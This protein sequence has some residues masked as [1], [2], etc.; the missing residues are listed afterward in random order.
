MTG[1]LD[2]P[3]ELRIHIF[4]YVP[5]LCYGR[6]E[7]VGP[8]VRLTP[9]ICRA[10]HTLRRDALLLYAKTSFFIIQSDDS[11]DRVHSSNETRVSIWLNTLGDRALSYVE[12]LQLSR[13]WKL[14]QPSRWQGHVG[15]YVRLQLL[16]KKWQ[17]T[18]GTYPVAHDIRG[19]R[20]ESVDL[21][22]YLISQRLQSS[23]KVGSEMGLSRPDIEFI[24]EA[25]D[26]VAS[27]PISTFDTE[28][29][30]AG[31]Q[32][33]RGWWD[34]AP[35]HTTSAYDMQ[36]SEAGKQQRRGIWDEMEQQLLALQASGS[37]VELRAPICD[38]STCYT[39][40]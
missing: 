16:D 25:M 34:V 22:R 40:Y 29:S 32:R 14:K 3:T 1:I 19:M 17:V 30:Q 12:N 13:H 15:F 7:T 11:C 2:V 23:S 20:A 28:S 18:A 9:A 27:H 5:D 6:H 21:L 35:S 4:S 26:I 37:G 10:N 31:W 38:N 8:N 33:P 36:Q 24:T 39:P